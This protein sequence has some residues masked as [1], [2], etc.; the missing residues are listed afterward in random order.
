MGSWCKNNCSWFIWCRAEVRR[1]YR[2]M[3]INE[4]IFCALVQ[5][6]VEGLNN[7]SNDLD[8]ELKL[9]FLN[10]RW[11]P[12]AENLNFILSNNE[13]QNLFGKIL[14]NRMGLN[15]KWL[16]VFYEMS[17]ACQLAMASAVREKNFERHLQAEGEM[18]KFCFAFDHIN[19][20]RYLTYQHV[21]LR[22][23][24]RERSKAVADLNE[25][26]FGV[27]LSGLPFTSLHGDLITEIFIG[28]TKRQAGPHAAGFST[29]INKVNDWVRTAHIHTKLRCIFTEKI[30]LLTNSCHKECTPGARKLHVSN[31]KASKQQLRIYGW[32]PFAEVNARDIASFL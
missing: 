23:L 18:I 17:M 7:D 2:N 32:D 20:S 14:N 26:G 10:L 1:Y 9:L 27:S 6:R 12:T 3:R 25:Q 13:F 19:Y 28:Q 29:D 5:H 21:Y 15:Q 30:K 31:V 16:S 4:E 11:K 24:Q 8:M 22:T